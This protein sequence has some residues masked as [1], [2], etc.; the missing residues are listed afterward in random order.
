M[1]GWYFIKVTCGARCLVYYVCHFPVVPLLTF[2]A[3]GDDCFKPSNPLA[4]P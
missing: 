4:F 2:L 1:I 3:R